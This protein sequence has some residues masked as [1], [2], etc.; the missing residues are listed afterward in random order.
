[1]FTYKIT[2]FPAL[3]TENIET[4]VWTAIDILSHSNSMGFVGIIFVTVS[5]NL[6]ILA[7][8]RYFGAHFGAFRA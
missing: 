7:Y 1:M 2:K 8:L 4:H 5:W 3:R 6:T